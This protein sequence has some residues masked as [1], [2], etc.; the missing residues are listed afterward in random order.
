MYLQCYINEKG[1]KVY[2]TKVP[3]LDFLVSSLFGICLLIFVY[4]DTKSL[5]FLVR[6]C[7]NVIKWGEA[8]DFWKVNFNFFSRLR[9][10]CVSLTQWLKFQN[11]YIWFD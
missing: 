8:T 10:F 11:M 3:F 5:F 6:N 1:E 7:N 4:S 2:T 9:E